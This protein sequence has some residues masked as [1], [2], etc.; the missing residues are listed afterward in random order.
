M[1]VLV[2]IG[3][4]AGAVILAF[5]FAKGGG[6]AVFA[7]AGAEPGKALEFLT[8]YVVKKETSPFA[9]LLC[10][11]ILC[12]WLVCLAIWLAAR[13][14][15]EAAK[16]IGIAWCLLAFVACGFEHSVA[17]M[18]AVT[19]GLLAPTP[20]GTLSGAAYNLGVVTLGNL[21]GGALFVAGAY[22]WAA[23][24]EAPATAAKDAH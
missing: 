19:L 16:M 17:N 13:L 4:L 7:P 14:K 22:L 3:N 8:A 12:N 18:T 9:P 6:G 23:R 5:L 15:S 24:G 1:F 10:R 21:I 20:I 11:A 2:W